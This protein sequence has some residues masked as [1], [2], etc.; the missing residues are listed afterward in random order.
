MVALALTGCNAP[1][2]SGQ[3]ST[4]TPPAATTIV[5]FK[6]ATD[7]MVALQA[8]NVDAAVNDSPVMQ[9]LVK[10][11]SKGLKVIGE[12]PTAEMYRFGVRKNDPALLAGINAGLAKIVASGE[13]AK[14]YKQWFGVEPSTMPTQS[15]PAKAP[16]GAKIK[17]VKAGQLTVGSDTSFP[18]FESLNGN[19]VE[20]FDVDMMNAIA[21]TMGITKVV[22]V[23]ES[24]DTLWA[25]TSA[26]KFDVVASGAFGTPERKQFVDFS[27]PYGIANQGIAVKKDSPIKVIA[28]LA[29]KKIAVQSGTTGE[30]WVR[31]NF[32]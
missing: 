5:P 2:T 31:E 27:D 14:I 1:T 22:F 21:K 17:L 19:K 16:A 26:G 28:D 12:A 25:S 20:G 4:T 8:G 6:T 18:P 11:P 9:Y 29:G 32:K 13:Y 30:A 10:D 7:Q 24:F 23:T 3:K 15:A